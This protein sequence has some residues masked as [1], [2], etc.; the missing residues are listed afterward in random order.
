MIRT[1]LALGW[2]PLRVYLTGER[3]RA[4]GAMA[5]YE[6]VRVPRRPPRRVPQ[7]LPPLRLNH[8]L[9]CEC[10]NAPIALAPAEP[11]HL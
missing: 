8:C 9:C 11:L 1:R 7:Q 10:A 2:L 5:A 3:E 6:K 4:D